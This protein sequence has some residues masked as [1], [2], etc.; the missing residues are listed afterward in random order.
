MTLPFHQRFEQD[1]RGAD[2]RDN[3]QNQVPSQGINDTIGQ[4]WQVSFLVQWQQHAEEQADNHGSD[5]VADE[6]K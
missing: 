5:K 6:D 1:P 3:R 4:P 2:A